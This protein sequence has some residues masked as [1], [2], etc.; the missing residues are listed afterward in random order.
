[1]QPLKIGPFEKHVDRYE[2]WFERNRFAYESEIQA[3]RVLLPQ[4]GVGLEIGV[5]SGRFAAPLSVRIGIE[6]SRA[7]AI[8]AQKRE[9]QVIQA[10]AEALPFREGEFDFALIIT[11]LC[12]LS[13]VGVSL[14]EAHRVLKRSGSLI[15]GF[16]D[17]ESPLGQLYQSGKDESL[18]YRDAQFY[19]V[20]E[21]VS[22]MKNAGFE[23]FVFTQTIFQDLRRIQS[24][25]AVR[26][27]YGDGSFVVVRGMK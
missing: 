1:M 6:P 12:F 8:V 23:G 21:V 3:V 19:S 2:A 11:T 13:E 17:R 22:F 26:P 15:V 16:V 5:G 7:M 25:E 20:G 24:A 27:G 4:R 18:F 14:Q 9:I 10:V